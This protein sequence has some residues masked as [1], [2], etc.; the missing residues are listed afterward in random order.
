[1]KQF[2]SNKYITAWT[3][4]MESIVKPE[5]VV[6]IDGSEEQLEQLLQ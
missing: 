2:T 5:R 1:M 4:Y 3:E 6:L